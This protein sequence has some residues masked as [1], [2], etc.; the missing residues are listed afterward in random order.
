MLNHQF[1]LD[2]AA[3]WA[4][5]LRREAV[6]DVQRQAQMAFELAYS[7]QPIKEE[8]DASL[9]FVSDHGLD[10]LCRVLVNSNEIIYLE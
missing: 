10:G 2:M 9:D 8:L 1:T 6:D 4:D 7:R 5:R 3:H